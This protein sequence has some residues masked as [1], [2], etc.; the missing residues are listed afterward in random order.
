LATAPTKVFDAEQ[1]TNGAKEAI[2]L[3]I[4]YI[5]SVEITGSS[6]I[7]FH[8][9]NTEA[10]AEKAA[11][12]KNSAAKKTDNVESYVYRTSEGHLGIPGQNFVSSLV[13]TGK[14]I[15]DPRS[16]R[17]SAHDLY[18]AAII[19]LDIVAPL[20]PKTK[21]WD[22][23]DRR[24]VTVQRSAVTRTRPAMKEG[25]K[26]QFEVMINTPEYLPALKLQEVIAMAGRLTGL[27]DYR[28][29]FGRFNMTGFK[30]RTAT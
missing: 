21:K 2:D 18:E 11:A 27:C 5:A 13:E 22:Y 8:A 12:A 15:Q 16:P 7:L 23:D 19:P 24:R 25:W 10:V 6:P 28:P 3:T 17:K 4:P 14:Y 20:M 30:V 9:W 1:V 29:T 26:I